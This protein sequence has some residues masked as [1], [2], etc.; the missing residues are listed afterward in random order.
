MIRPGIAR[1]GETVAGME[2]L[3]CLEASGAMMEF[4]EVG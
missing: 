1:N 2:G 3:T 4:R